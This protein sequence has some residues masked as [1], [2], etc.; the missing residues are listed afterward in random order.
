MLDNMLNFFAMLAQRESSGTVIK[1]CDFA[2][3]W[4]RPALWIIGQLQQQRYDESETIRKY[5]KN[6]LVTVTLKSLDKIYG[7]SPLSDSAE[8]WDYITRHPKIIAFELDQKF[9]ELV[10]R[11]PT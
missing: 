3:D 7:H 4:W 5:C 10:N 11:Q 2:Y 1:H 8:V 6:Q 9:H